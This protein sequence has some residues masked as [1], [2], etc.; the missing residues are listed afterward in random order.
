MKKFFKWVLLPLFLLGI[1]AAGIGAWWVFYG[2]KISNTHNYKNVGEIPTPYGYE[3]VMEGDFGYTNFLRALP[4]SPRGT[5]VE[6]YTGGKANLQY[7]NYAVIDLPLL[8]NYE[9]CA[10]VCMRL[11]SEYLYSTQQYNRIRFQDVNGK[12]LRYKGGDSRK[13][14]EKYLRNLYGVAS[15]FSLSRELETRPLS[16]IQPGDVFVYPARKGHKYGHAIIVIDV[17]VNKEGKRAFLLAEGNTPARSIHV[18]RNL[19]SP[20]LS[21][22]FV[23]D[24]DAKDFSLSIFH[25][26]ASELKHF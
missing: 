21:P 10:D 8:S 5:K 20:L 4:L 22:W 15:T 23:V 13:A 19:R 25:Y 9:Q 6:L 2:N 7:L 17:A 1:I 11:R 3:R 14:F 16:E 12:M 26:N 18:I 24:E